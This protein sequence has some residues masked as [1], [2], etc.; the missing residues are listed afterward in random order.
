MDVVQLSVGRRLSTFFVFD[1]I[2]DRQ[3]GA[4]Q[5]VPAD[6]HELGVVVER[7]DDM[8]G[9]LG[10]FGGVQDVP[11]L[12]GIARDDGANPLGEQ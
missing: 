1:S 5:R 4:D 11:E 10:R 8:A 12:V 9:Q 6:F 7:P 2:L 3:F